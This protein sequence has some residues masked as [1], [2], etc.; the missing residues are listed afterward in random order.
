MM[1]WRQKAAAAYMAGASNVVS[2]AAKNMPF[3]KIF[4]SEQ[5]PM[6]RFMYL[7][8]MN[9]Y[10]KAGEGSDIMYDKH[11]PQIKMHPDAWFAY[12]YG[13]DWLNRKDQIRNYTQR[14][15]PAFMSTRFKNAPTFLS[16]NNDKKFPV[17]AGFSPDR[18]DTIFTNTFNAPVK[19][20]VFNT[21]FNGYITRHTNPL[22]EYGHE[23]T[24]V[25]TYP[26]DYDNREK[27][28]GDIRRNT[29]RA[30]SAKSYNDEDGY[31]LTYP[32][33][34]E[35]EYP[36][37]AANLQQDIR[38]QMGAPAVNIDPKGNVSA[39]SPQQF[40]N[41]LNKFPYYTDGKLTDR[42]KWETYLRTRIEN[43]TLDPEAARWHNMRYNTLE[44]GTKAIQ[45]NFINN[46]LKF[47]PLTKNH[48][49]IYEKKEQTV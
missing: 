12:K 30:Y 41:Y 17:S 24:H 38:R 26:T 21:K 28:Y 27:A 10:A 37:I 29:F 23:A 44:K 15:F 16:L 14:V 45:D 7:S 2:P 8:A 43:S 49:S 20:D 36:A 32:D 48:R 22:S 33:Y 11:T 19:D 31:N 6:N 13:K 5:N 40:N 47:L 18:F 42:V 34:S 25:I 1:N 9:G 3:F 46:T 39:W 35:F 4:E